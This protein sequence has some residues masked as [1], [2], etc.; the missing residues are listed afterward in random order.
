MIIA[1]QYLCF[2]HLPGYTTKPYFSFLLHLGEP[3]RL[4]TTHQ[5]SLGKVRLLHLYTNLWKNEDFQKEGKATRQKEFRSAGLQY[6]ASQHQISL[7]LPCFVTFKS[8]PINKHVSCARGHKAH[9]VSRRCSRDPLRGMGPD[10]GVV[11]PIDSCST[12]WQRVCPTSSGA[13]PPG[14]LPWDSS[15]KLPTKSHQHSRRFC[16]CQPQPVHSANLPTFQ[17]A[18]ATTSPKSSVSQH[19]GA[20]RE[21]PPSL[22]LPEYPAPALEVKTT[23]HICQSSIPI[24]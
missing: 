5:G 2:P 20:E 21:I 19:L 15:R 13:H 3:M 6:F 22:F 9:L 14:K 16:T 23:S 11:F 1:H 10:S 17:L 12:W 7:S 24:I 18:T 8:D 4:V